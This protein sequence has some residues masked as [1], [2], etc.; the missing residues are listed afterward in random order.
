VTE[1]SHDGSDVRKALERVIQGDVTAVREL[2]GIDWNGVV[3]A[4]R[5]D[6]SPITREAARRAARKP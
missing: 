1:V 5:A 4:M 3:Q 2:E 6:A